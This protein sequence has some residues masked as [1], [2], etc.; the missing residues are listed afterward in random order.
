MR[1]FQ[2]TTLKRSLIR[3]CRMFLLATL[4]IVMAGCANVSLIQRGT[5]A[6]TEM[7]FDAD[8]AHIKV[9][10]Q[11]YVAREAAAGGRVTGGGG[12]GCTM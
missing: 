3:S 12:C 1:P 8:P 5:L 2:R 10:D 11:V 6:K 9:V 4:A 7:Q